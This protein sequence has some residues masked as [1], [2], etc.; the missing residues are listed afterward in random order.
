MVPAVRSPRICPEIWS[1]SLAEDGFDGFDWRLQRFR[2]ILFHK[3]TSELHKIQCSLTDSCSWG[4]TFTLLLTCRK[5]QSFVIC[6]LRP[7]PTL[8]LHAT[9]GDWAAGPPHLLALLVGL[10]LL[11]TQT[12]CKQEMQNISGLP[13]AF[14]NSLKLPGAFAPF[15]K[16]PEGSQHVVSWNFLNS[17]SALQSFLESLGGASQWQ[18]DHRIP[19]LFLALVFRLHSTDGASGKKNDIY[20]NIYIYSHLLRE[21]IPLVADFKGRGFW[22]MHEKWCQMSC[23]S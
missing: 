2:L 4:E 12:G 3:K 22:R 9:V 15:Q 5:G 1:Q 17:S 7:P 13:R 20:M 11:A 23:S 6:L 14:R 16:I 21:S 19:R 10:L 18:Q 8:L